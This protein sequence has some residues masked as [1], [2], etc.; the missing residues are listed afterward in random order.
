MEQKVQKWGNS[1]AVRIPKV[2][3]REL[4]LQPGSEIEIVSEGGALVLRPRPKRARR[5]YDLEEMLSRITDENMQP[6]IDF[7][8][9]V[10]KEKWEYEESR[11]DALRS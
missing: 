2:M 9:P 11:Q 8:P 6:F 7:G 4:A 1:L 3:A 5:Q 10:G